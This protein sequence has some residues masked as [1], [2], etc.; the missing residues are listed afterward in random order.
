MDYDD[1]DE[2]NGETEH[3][4]WVDYDYNANTGELDYIDDDS[5]EY[6][7]SFA[8]PSNLGVTAQPSGSRKSSLRS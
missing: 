1:L 3:D 5:E 2:Y 6:D 4:M 7:D 8:D